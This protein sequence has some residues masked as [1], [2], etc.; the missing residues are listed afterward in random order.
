MG[1]RLF[2]PAFTST[3]KEMKTPK[4]FCCGGGVIFLITVGENSPYT[5]IELPSD[6]TYF[7]NQKEVI[8]LPNFH[9]RVT[10]VEEEKDEDYVFVH[11]EE[12]SRANLL[13]FKKFQQKK[14]IWVDRNIFNEENTHY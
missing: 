12:I 8:L 13:N 10:K 3:S 6:W 14:L 11:I 9:F 2:W 5:N 1:S 7:S 4:D